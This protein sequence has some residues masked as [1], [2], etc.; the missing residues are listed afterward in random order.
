MNQIVD[1][2][3][4]NNKKEKSIPLIAIFVLFTIIALFIIFSF[5]VYAKIVSEEDNIYEDM[6]IIEKTPI[7]E[8]NN[9]I[10]KIEKVEEQENKKEETV[11]N[12][13]KKEI[14][15]KANNG[16]TYSIIGKLNI[17]SLNIEYGI[18][19]S[20]STE[21]LKISLNRYW[22]AYPNEVGNMVV[23]GHNYKNNKFFS[24]LPKIQIG[25]IVKIT[26][27]NGK[28][29]DYIVYDTS[30]ID[31]YN[32]SCTSQLTN[33]KTEI[34]LITCYYENGNPHATKRFVVKARVN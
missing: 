26:D 6:P 3:D 16:E 19:S 28:T 4:S 1:C 32:N 8:K 33:G 23:I 2:Y 18:L 11:I 21:L 10:E 31:P 20:S 30:V 24:N 34:T 15:Y 9:T 27:V 14:Q 5:N 29:L 7:Q 13:N 22:G 12:E 17:P 25:D